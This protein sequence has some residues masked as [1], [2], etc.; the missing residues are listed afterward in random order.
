MTGTG[1]RNGCRR[2]TCADQPCFDGVR[3][4]DGPGG[5][6]CGPC[7]TGYHGD[8]TKYRQGCRHFTCED[9]PCFPGATCEDFDDG[10][11]CGPCPAGEFGNITVHHLFAL[12][13]C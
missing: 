10:F 11:Q 13:V 7:P 4:T 9:N 12:F 1:L 6:K 2:M 8:G 3:C 5:F